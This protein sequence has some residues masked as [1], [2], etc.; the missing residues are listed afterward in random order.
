MSRPSCSTVHSTDPAVNLLTL[1]QTPDYTARGV[2]ALWGNDN[3]QYPSN[4]SS[5]RQ[6]C[7]VV[8]WTNRILTLWTNNNMTTILK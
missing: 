4:A 6:L 2:G 3:G 5:T 1:R 8:L 7:D